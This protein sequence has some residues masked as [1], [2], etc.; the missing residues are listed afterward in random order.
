MS[1]PRKD[2]LEFVLEYRRNLTT[3]VQNMV[4]RMPD[5]VAAREAPV[6][7]VNSYQRKLDCETMLNMCLILQHEFDLAKNLHSAL[8]TMV[9][10]QEALEERKSGWYDELPDLKRA[11]YRYDF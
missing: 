6:I 2:P 1:S 3:A 4:K 9:K 11:R 8:H 7:V 10:D 5:M